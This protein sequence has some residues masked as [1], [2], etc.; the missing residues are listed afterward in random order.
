MFYGWLSDA[1]AVR[2]CRPL[3]S[4]T[5]WICDLQKGAELY[6]AVW[7][8]SGNALF[9]D[10]D[11]VKSYAELGGTM[12][13][14]NGRPVMVGFRPVLFKRNNQIMRGSG[15]PIRH[16]AVRPAYCTSLTL[17]SLN[18]TFMPL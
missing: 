18:V 6:R 3:A 9:R 8:T 1:A 11:R 16:R 5:L 13:A 2:P 17:P 15:S 12:Q 14:P 4:S 7:S 10:M